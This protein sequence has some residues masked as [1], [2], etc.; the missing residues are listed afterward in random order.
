MTRLPPS[1]FERTCDCRCP[2]HHGRHRFTYNDS[3]C[4][5]R[6]TCAT[7]PTTLLAPRGALFL[8]YHGD[9][10]TVPILAPDRFD[11]RHA[12][13]VTTDRDPADSAIARLLRTATAELRQHLS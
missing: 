4:Q 7:Q 12:A 10:W 6:I 2:T 13:P 11:W 5:C 9:L 8:N 3:G 1:P